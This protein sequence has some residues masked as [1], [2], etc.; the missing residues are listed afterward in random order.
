[1]CC[2]YAHTYGDRKRG[3]QLEV[4]EGPPPGFGFFEGAKSRPRVYV[5]RR[6]SCV[7]VCNEPAQEGERNPKL[8]Q[9]R[10]RY[11]N[12]HIVRLSATCAYNY[13]TAAKPQLRRRILSDIQA[14]Q[15]FPHR[16]PWHQ[17]PE[18]RARARWCQS[19]AAACHGMT[20]SANADR[21]YQ[22]AT[23]VELN[24]VEV[25]GELTIVSRV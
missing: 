13:R 16:R 10:E 19:D 9:L 11:V 23:H 3:N 15:Y 2:T 14:N 25:H 1:M 5:R 6:Q 22:D 24:G 7:D 18:G 12:K 17:Q 4:I 8:Q 21:I 20:S